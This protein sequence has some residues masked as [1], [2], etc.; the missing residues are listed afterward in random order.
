MK[1]IDISYIND[2]HQEIVELQIIKIKKAVYFATEDVGEG[3]YQDFLD[4]TSQFSK[5]GIHT[6][7]DKDGKLIFS[8]KQDT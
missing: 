4:I 5:Y 7:Y 6:A 2:Q 3:K 1:N 8:D